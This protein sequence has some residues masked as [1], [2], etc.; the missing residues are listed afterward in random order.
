ML[1]LRKKIQSLSQT[2]QNIIT[3][4]LVLFNI[5]IIIF[6]INFWVGLRKVPPP[7]IVEK[8]KPVEEIAEPYKPG[9]VGEISEEE[10]KEKNILPLPPAVFNT[11]GKIL[12]VKSDRLIV[13][14][15]GSNFS[16]QKPRTLTLIFT[17]STTV[18][19]PKTKF[20]S[21][22]LEGLKYLKPGMEISI[23]SPINIRG[24]IEFET[25]S[26]NVL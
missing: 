7:K 19:D 14:G 6:W 16:D 13:Q 26:I 5:A 15:S 10:I 23:E 9:E 4:I 3:V 25:S 2:Q 8:P 24:K 1:N 20:I 22:G 11:S 18:Y 12:E 17:G 21:Q